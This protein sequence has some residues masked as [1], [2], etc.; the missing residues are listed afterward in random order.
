MTSLLSFFK[1]Y[2][3]AHGKSPPPLWTYG[4]SPIT[5]VKSLLP[6]LSPLLPIV[7]PLHDIW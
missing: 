3:P 5:F 6:M 4:K 7:S 1:Y 2:P